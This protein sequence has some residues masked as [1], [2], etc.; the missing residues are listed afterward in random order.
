MLC[1]I[2]I[3]INRTPSSR[4]ATRWTRVPD[5]FT[6]VRDVLNYF[7]PPRSSTCLRHLAA[8]AGTP[9]RC[10]G[11][12]PTHPSIN[13]ASLDIS[14][15]APFVAARTR[16]P[17]PLRSGWGGLR[18]PIKYR[19]LGG[20]KRLGVLLLSAPPVVKCVRWG[21]RILLASARRL[22]NQFIITLCLRP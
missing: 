14:R 4:C 13:L 6:L 17:A 12:T 2:F 22:L 11:W 8:R 18:P 1:A 3:F 15:P 20:S 10:V 16:V 19:R 9:V 7:A 5:D 21:R